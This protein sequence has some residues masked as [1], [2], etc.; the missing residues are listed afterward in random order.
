MNVPSD[1][2]RSG[3]GLLSGQYR[4]GELLGTGGSASVFAATD[5]TSGEPVALKILHPHL[6]RSEPLREGFFAEARA[7]AGLRH[8]NVASVLG[9]GVHTNPNTDAIEE[10]LAWIAL[11]RAAG[12]SLAE[13]VERFGALDVAQSLA[14][15]GGVLQALEAAHAVGLIHRDVSPANI[16]VAPD[17]DGVISSTGVR[18]VDFGLAD[19][20]G[21]PVLGS[22]VL[23]ST[24]ADDVATAEMGI[25]GSANYMSPE[26]ARGEAVDE[27]GDLY[28]VGCVLHFALTGRPPFARESAEAVMQA[29][30]QTPPPVPSVLFSGI[31]R[32]ADRLVVKAMLKDPASRFSSATQMFAAVTELS[33]LLNLADP[34]AGTTVNRGLDTVAGL[35]LGLADRTRVFGA[36]SLD[37]LDSVFGPDSAFGLDSAAGDEATTVF[38]RLRAKPSTS[39][40]TTVPNALVEPSP[41]DLALAGD[42][43]DVNFHDTPLDASRRRSSTAIWIGA[44]ILASVIAVAWILAVNG[45]T[46]TSLAVPSASASASPSA[47]VPSARPSTSAVAAETVPLPDLS[48]LS[49]DKARTAL[50]AAGLRLGMVTS[51]NSARVADTVLSVSVQSAEIVAGEPMAPGQAVD[52]LVASGLNTIPAIAGMPQAAAVAAVQSAG[53]AVQILQQ[54]SASV[55][56][57]T[58]IG[59]N[60]STG[61]V[62]SL[63][64]PVVISVA[65]APA[66]TP[67]PSPTPTPKASPS[68]SPSP[69]ARPSSS[70]SAS[71]VPSASATATPPL[72]V[73]PLTQ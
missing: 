49:L 32:S 41:F 53:F 59:S 45:S 68:V 50:L 21:R 7:A 3:E 34:D 19:A 67:T 29:H 18:L 27:R 35:G 15:A 65:M 64:S 14:V 42:T 57:G 72:T 46:P 10:P 8:A 16:M 62:Q 30:T 28:Q 60:P 17:A 56:P 58:V 73:G 38:P 47:A 26:Q 25:L 2:L 23:R 55:A 51:A 12:V 52:L 39:G 37:A 20:A 43:A 9:V 40:G 66:P 48:T 44:V 5:V 11:E 1:G 36:D 70:P 24:A 4:L 61:T 71:P 33:A 13:H 31:P 54:S 6:S 22:D 63:T 69:T